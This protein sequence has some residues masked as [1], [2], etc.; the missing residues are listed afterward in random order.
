MRKLRLRGRG[1]TFLRSHGQ[2][3][4]AAGFLA[5]KSFHGLASSNSLLAP[6]FVDL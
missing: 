4:A 6:C 3:V 2:L 5:P 1:M